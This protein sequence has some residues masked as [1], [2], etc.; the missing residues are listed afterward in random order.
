LNGFTFTKACPTAFQKEI[1]K[2][3]PIEQ[4]YCRQKPESIKEKPLPDDQINF[5]SCPRPKQQ[6]GQGIGKQTHSLL[7]MHKNRLN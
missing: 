3:K 6:K 1:L 5:P 2:T 4:R 7:Q